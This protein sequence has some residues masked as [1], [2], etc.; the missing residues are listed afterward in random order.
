MRTPSARSLRMLRVGRSSRLAALGLT[1]LLAL[2][3]FESAASPESVPSSASAP[4]VLSRFNRRAWLV[5]GEPIPESSAWEPSGSFR[6]FCGFS[7][8]RY[9]DPIV[10]PGRRGVSHLHMFFGNTRTRARSTYRSLRRWGSGTCQGGPLNR[11]AYWVPAMHNAAGR[12]V[13]PE[14]FELYYKGFGTQQMIRNIRTYPRGLRMI[15]GHDMTRRRLVRGE[16]S[17][18]GGSTSV[19]LPRCG[20][21]QELR[22]ELRFPMCWNGRQIDSAN[23]RRHMAYGTGGGGWITQQG[24]CPRTH[25][26]HL[27]ELTVIVVYTSDGN[28]NNWYLSSDRMPGMRHAN[29]STFHSDWFGAWDPA[30]QATWTQECIREMRSCVWG[31]LG[32]GTRLRNW[33]GTY[34]GPQLIAP[35]PR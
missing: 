19:T 12:V 18:A 20:R 23:H 9:S 26:I 8:L 35:P 29:G 32:N 24:G 27:P 30:V 7:H 5:T 4:S 28:T 34:R 16:W 13:V 14:Y 21:G 11:T 25:P 10:Y 22:V 33:L 6:T 15:A 1:A 2:G 17:C 3:P 31:E